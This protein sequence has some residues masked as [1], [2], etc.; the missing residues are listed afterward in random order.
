MYV[1]LWLCENGRQGRQR[2]IDAM[3]EVIDRGALVE[4]SEPHELA[5]VF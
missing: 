2:E 5:A 4:P 1:I 3:T